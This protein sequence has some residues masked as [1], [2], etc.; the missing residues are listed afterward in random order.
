MITDFSVVNTST[1][2]VSDSWSEDSRDLT[3]QQFLRW[4][5]N[6]CLEEFENANISDINQ[7]VWNNFHEELVERNIQWTYQHLIA[8]ARKFLVDHNIISWS[9]VEGEHTYYH[10]CD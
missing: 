9:D 6:E 8:S 2:E 4:C 5:V 3:N 1:G 7:W 10:C